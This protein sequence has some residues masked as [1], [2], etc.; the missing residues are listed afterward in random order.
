VRAGSGEM[1]HPC[2]RP[3]AEPRR[4][5]GAPPSG[6]PSAAPVKGVRRQEGA[7]AG[8]RG[9][10]YLFLSYL[11]HASCASARRH[12]FGLGIF[13]QAAIFCIFIFVTAAARGRRSRRAGD[14]TRN[15]NPSSRELVLVPLRRC[16][17]L[18]CSDYCVRAPARS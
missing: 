2:G 1:G 9:R 15:R 11:S 4:R 3:T 5:G 6:P 14:D 16:L 12:F 13:L 17:C 18:L 10:A 8:R 7:E